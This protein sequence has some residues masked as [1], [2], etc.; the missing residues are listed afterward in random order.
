MGIRTLAPAAMPCSRPAGWSACRAVV[1][2][3]LI[4]GIKSLRMAIILSVSR[5]RSS[6]EKGAGSG[7]EKAEQVKLL[8]SLAAATPRGGQNPPLAAAPRW[9][10]AEKGPRPRR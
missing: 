10:R 3:M 1:A 9:L 4:E 2:A 8:D 5:K 7:R 6:R